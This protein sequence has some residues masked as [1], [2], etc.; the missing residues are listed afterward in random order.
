M[1]TKSEIEAN[2]KSN[3][4]K[5]ENEKPRA[6][7]V[8]KPTNPKNKRSNPRA[9]KRIE[10]KTAGKKSAARGK[11]GIRIQ[12]QKNG[13]TPNKALD[14]ALR[15]NDKPLTFLQQ[16]QI[17]NDQHRKAAIYQSNTSRSQKGTSPSTRAS[18]RDVP[19][20]DLVQHAA[21]VKM[22]LLADA[23]NHMDAGRPADT[24]MRWAGVG[25][26]GTN[27]RIISGSFE[28]EAERENSVDHL[29]KLRPDIK[30]FVGHINIS[31]PIK[32]GRISAEKWQE[33]VDDARHGLGWMTVFRLSQLS[34]ATLKPT[35]FTYI[36]PVYQLMVRYTINQT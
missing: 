32:T 28:S 7:K 3:A 14:Y 10:A 2:I 21:R 27:P 34:T 20:L 33:I 17:L 30:N 36:S 19:S 11:Y 22:F 4:A 15:R 29:S 23:A 12:L 16:E 25:D 18:L 35:M 26:V 8:K 24:Q 13:R 9:M 31:L 5:R 6:E 1:S